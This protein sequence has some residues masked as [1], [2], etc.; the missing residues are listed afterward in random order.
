MSEQTRCLRCRKN[1]D[2][3]ILCQSCK[4]E[5]VPFFEAAK[6]WQL[7]VEL[8]HAQQLF[9]RRKRDPDVQFF[10]H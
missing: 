9:K 2:G 7:A 10:S 8:E 4:S 6:D 5:L 1:I 3:G